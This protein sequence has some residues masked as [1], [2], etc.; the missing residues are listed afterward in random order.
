MASHRCQWE[1]WAWGGQSLQQD[2][3]GLACRPRSPGRWKD[4]SEIS[5]RFGTIA[6]GVSVHCDLKMFRLNMQSC[7]AEQCGSV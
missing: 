5:E 2:C 6:S 4:G 3:W 7:S 1:V